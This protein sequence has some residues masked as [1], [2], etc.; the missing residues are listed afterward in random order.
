M[1]RT[2]AF[3]AVGVVSMEC[4]SAPVV[5][6]DAARDGFA[7]FAHDPHWRVSLINETV[8]VASSGDLAVY[9]GAYNE[10]NSRAGVVMT[11]RIN[12]IAEF[13]RGDDGEWEMLWYMV[14]NMEPSHPM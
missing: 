14:A 12:F 5:G 3:D 4:G 11:H 6:I 2:T 9:R 7:L 13:R 8:D 10:E 1:T